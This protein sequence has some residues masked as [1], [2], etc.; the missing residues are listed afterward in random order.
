MKIDRDTVT[1]ISELNNL[2]KRTADKKRGRLTPFSV[3]QFNK[4]MKEIYK[5]SG[6]DVESRIFYDDKS[7]VKID[8]EVFYPV[9]NG[10]K[11]AFGWYEIVSASSHI[12]AVFPKKLSEEEKKEKRQ[13][14]FKPYLLA[15]MSVSDDLRNDINEAGNTILI[16]NG[17]WAVINE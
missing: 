13:V 7:P 12:F 9:V 17:E 5:N 2:A 11:Q 14:Y 15:I 10:V 6:W 4:G 1:F 3:L 8:N 16:D